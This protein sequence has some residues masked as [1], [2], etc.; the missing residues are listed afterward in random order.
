MNAQLKYADKRRSRAAVIQGSNER[1]APGGPLTAIRDL[2]L[3][4][5]LAKGAK[6]RADYLELRQRAQFTAPEAE[7]V[8]NGCGR[9][10]ARRRPEG[11]SRSALSSAGKGRP[12]ALAGR[13]PG[14]Q[15]TVSTAREARRNRLPSSQ[16]VIASSKTCRSRATF[17]ARST[18]KLPM[19]KP[20]KS[21]TLGVD[22]RRRRLVRHVLDDLRLGKVARGD[23]PGVHARAGDKRRRELVPGDLRLAGEREGEAEPAALADFPLKAHAL[24]VLERGAEDFRVGAPPGDEIGQFLQLL[25]PD[26]AGHLERPDIAGPAG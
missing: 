13:R 8:W 11:A 12:S 2:K 17:G 18:C 6:E 16:G 20:R 19:K 24:Q 22:E 9:C 4:A 21:R 26:R 7:L 23:G 1:D 14:A 25:Q 10:C 3:G 15:A 5:E